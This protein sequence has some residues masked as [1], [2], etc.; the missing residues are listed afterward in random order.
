MG[1]KWKNIAIKIFR[2][3]ISRI[4]LVLPKVNFF[5]QPQTIYCIASK[6]IQKMLILELWGKLCGFPELHMF[7]DFSLLWTAIACKA[8]SLS[9]LLVFY[10][11]QFST[12]VWVLQLIWRG[13]PYGKKYDFVAPQKLLKM[14]TSSSCCYMVHKIRNLTFWILWL[15]VWPTN[16]S[17]IQFSPTCH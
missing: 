3:V 1:A 4:I 6:K 13:E 14:L 5:A 16:S 7:S 8:G 11:H 9:H 17:I 15:L 12:F 10:F 2:G